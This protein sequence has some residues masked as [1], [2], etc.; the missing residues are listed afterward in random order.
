[1]RSVADQSRILKGA[2][3]GTARFQNTPVA[4]CL[5]TLYDGRQATTDANGHYQIADVPYG[6]YVAKAQKEEDGKFLTGQV[7]VQIESNAAI[8]DVKLD[9][10][11]DQYRTLILD[12]KIHTHYTYSIILKLTDHRRDLPFHQ[13]LRVG[14]FGTHAETQIVNV[15]DS[16]N[17]AETTLSIKADWNLDKSITV[18]FSFHLNKATYSNVSRV[19]PDSSTGWGCNVKSEGDDA[20]VDFNLQNVLRQA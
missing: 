16:D 10:P 2:L 4:G 18:A 14:P 17:H 11:P 15:A 13:E 12:G 7:N 20:H 1:M 19:N 9:L 6:N 3:S 5:I 8:A